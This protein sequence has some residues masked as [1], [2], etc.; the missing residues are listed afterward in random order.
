MANKAEHSNVYLS[1]KSAAH[2]SITDT[3]KSWDSRRAWVLQRVSSLRQVA[4][5]FPFGF[6]F[7]K[8]NY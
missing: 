4:L 7:L 1:S 6:R 3:A 8:L 5:C 2:Y